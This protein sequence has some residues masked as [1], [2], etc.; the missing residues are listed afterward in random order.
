MVSMGRR[1]GLWVNTR[2]SFIPD[3]LPRPLATFCS[4]RITFLSWL[5]I[6]A[7]EREDVDR[8]A[9]VAGAAVRFADVDPLLAER[10]PDGGQD[11]GAVRGHRPG[12]APARLIFA[13]R[14]PRDLDAALGIGVERLRAA[15][16]VDR[17]AATARDEAED[18]VAGQRIAA[19][20][21]AD[22]HVVDAVEADAAVVAL[23]DLA[24]EAA[25]CALR[26]AAPAGSRSCRRPSTAARG[27]RATSFGSIL[28]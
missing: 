23:D 16:A 21:V 27:T 12:A 13:L 19:L 5:E 28:P 6:R 7:D 22:E 2:I 20:G 11:A 14:V 10:V 8:L 15:A 26:G 4:A 3:R 25:R 9:V 24:D 18:V 17:D 1:R